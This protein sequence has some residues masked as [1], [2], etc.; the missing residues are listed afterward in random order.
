MVDTDMRILYDEYDAIIYYSPT[1]DIY[2]RTMYFD[3]TIGGRQ[4]SI[5]DMDIHTNFQNFDKLYSFSS[6]NLS[7][8]QQSFSFNF[9]N[10]NIK[11]DKT[12]KQ[13]EKLYTHQFTYSILSRLNRKDIKYP[14]YSVWSTIFLNHHV[15]NA[16]LDEVKK[17]HSKESTI[18]K[19]HIKENKN[20]EQF[21]IFTL[22][23]LNELNI[24]RILDTMKLTHLN[25][26]DNHLTN[27]I[28][29]NENL[30]KN[31]IKRVSKVHFS[32]QL[33]SINSYDTF[34]PT[35]S[36][37]SSFVGMKSVSHPQLSQLPSIT[38]ID[39]NE[40]DTIDALSRSNS[41][42][43]FNLT[44]N[45]KSELLMHDLDHF[46]NDVT[47]AGKDAII[48]DEFEVSERHI[49]QLNILLMRP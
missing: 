29:M 31:D 24:E 5:P 18:K 3:L 8:L 11:H 21:D 36:L 39:M 25:P 27:S 4:P 6:K 7:N 10:T 22:Q 28:K 19:N 13:Y 48:L 30:S 14:E 47:T 33:L 49:E 16:L 15:I 41:R 42:A 35:P 26:N 46:L 45:Q 38:E 9:D 12:S 32:D 20:Y 34:V 43:Q 1:Y 37:S 44:S 17:D 2:S 40:D 23:R